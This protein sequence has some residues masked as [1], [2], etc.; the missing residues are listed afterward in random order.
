MIWWWLPPIGT[1]LTICETRT[2]VPDEL[3]APETECQLPSWLDVVSAT[4]TELSIVSRNIVCDRDE[5]AFM[6]VAP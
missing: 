4:S 3:D 5:P 1:A 2:A 6:S